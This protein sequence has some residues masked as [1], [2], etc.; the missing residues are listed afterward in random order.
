MAFA[1]PVKYVLGVPG[2]FHTRL[3][4]FPGTGSP[5]AQ[6]LYQFVLFFTEVGHAPVS[7]FDAGTAP[8]PLY[9]SPSRIALIREAP[10]AAT[11]LPPGLIVIG[12]PV[13]AAQVQL[14]DQPPTR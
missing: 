14:V 11:K 4:S 1:V 5:N 7:G 10:L 6:G 12:L 8:P 3:G 9:G 13:C 2:T